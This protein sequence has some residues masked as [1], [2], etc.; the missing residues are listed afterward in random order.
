MVVRIGSLCSGYG[1]LE[2]AVKAVLP[3][4]VP[5]WHAEVDQAACRVLKSATPDTPNLGD[6]RLIDWS[7]PELPCD[8]LTMGVPCQPASA[9]GRRTAEAD[10]RWL[11]PD[12][13]RTIRALRPPAFLFEN[14]EGLV[15]LRKGEVWRGILADMRTEGYAVRWLVMGACVVG[16]CH[17]RHRVFALGMYVGPAAPPAVKL[18][19]PKCGARRGSVHLPT[20]LARDASGRGEGGPAYWTGQIEKRGTKVG[21]PLGAIISAGL[22]PTPQARD[23]GRRGTPSRAGALAR[24]TRDGWEGVKE[25]DTV[26][27]LLAPSDST[28]DSAVIGERFGRYAGAVARWAQACG[29][30]PPEPTETGPR[31]GVRLAP[32]F[33]A[34]MMGLDF[35]LFDGESRADTLRMIG[36]GVMPA[37]GATALR[38]LFGEGG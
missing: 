35:G 38:L 13:R 33:P 29:V 14:V 37:Q 1:G 16:A 8:L 21:M 26:V 2:A 12:A 25:L 3:A 28:S 34:W 7:S 31:G 18:D 24:V 6:L 5:A 23:G 17:H 22:L 9:A 15:T 20:P 36:N 30:D 19:V 10:P 11:W 27:P 32:Q 4:A